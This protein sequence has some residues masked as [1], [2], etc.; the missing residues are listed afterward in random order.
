MMKTLIVLLL[1]VG[2]VCFADLYDD[3]LQL[4]NQREQ[5]RQVD[6]E[7]SYWLGEEG[8]FLRRLLTFG[9]AHRGFTSSPDCRALNMDDKYSYGGSVRQ[10]CVR[11]FCVNVRFRSSAFNEDKTPYFISIARVCKIVLKD[12]LACEYSIG[13]GPRCLDANGNYAGGSTRGRDGRHQ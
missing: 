6:Q 1:S 9:N 13:G 3:R 12:G 11:D 4:H 10:A 2:S 8:A 7:R 5:L